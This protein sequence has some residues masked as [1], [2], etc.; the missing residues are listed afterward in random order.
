MALKP[1]ALR[2]VSAS[3]GNVRS[4]RRPWRTAR[5]PSR[6][7][8]RIAAR[9]S[10]CSSFSAKRLKSG[11]PAMG[12]L[13]GEG[14]LKAVGAAPALP[15]RFA[16]RPVPMTPVKHGTEC[17]VK[18][19]VCEV[20]VQQAVSAELFVDFSADLI[21]GRARGKGYYQHGL[22]FWRAGLGPGC[23]AVCPPNVEQCL[24]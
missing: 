10:S 15:A 6:R 2:A 4:R 17:Q 24:T 3:S 7:V 19:W 23:H 5:F 14:G 13:L 12:T 9:S 22:R 16:D 8:P 20:S 21:S 11:F 18:G 1:D